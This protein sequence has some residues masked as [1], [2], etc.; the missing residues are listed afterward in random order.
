MFEIL[1][2]ISDKRQNSDLISLKRYPNT[3]NNP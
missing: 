2:P 1:K 3:F